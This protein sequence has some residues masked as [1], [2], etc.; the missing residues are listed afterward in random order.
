MKDKPRLKALF[1]T[2]TEKLPQKN[3]RITVNLGAVVSGLCKYVARESAAHGRDQRFV[4]RIVSELPDEERNIAL[5]GKEFR[6]NPGRCF[7]DESGAP[8]DIVSVQNIVVEKRSDR[9]QGRF[10]RPA[11]RTFRPVIF[12]TM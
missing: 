9:V 11:G 2:R 1:L 5:K 3:A 12:S 6:Q 10:L 8:N 7:A 4:L